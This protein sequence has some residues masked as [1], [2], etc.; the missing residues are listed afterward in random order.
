MS[1]RARWLA[2]AVCAVAGLAVFQFWGNS[3]R[4]YIDTR[5]LFY[6]WGWQWFDPASESEHGILILAAA[7]AL[8]VINFRELAGMAPTKAPRAQPAVAMLAGLAVH[9]LGYALQQTR[10]S[11]IGFLFF[12]WGA[13]ALGG[14]ARSARAA[15]F[16]LGFLVFAIPLNV[17]DT[18]GFYLRLGVIEVAYRL[19][20]AFGIGVLRNGTQ[21]LAPDGSY[22]YDVAAACSG[23]N[24]LMALAALSL[25]VGYLSFR[26]LRRRAL[27]ALLCV[28]FAFAGNVVRI[29]MII[30]VAAWKGQRA[31][32]VVHD[33]FGFLIFLIVLGLELGAVSLIRRWWPETPPVPATSGS[34]AVPPAWLAPGVIAAAV[35]LAATGMALAAH[36]LDGMQVDPRAGVR[37]AA[38]GVN[39]V[40]LP[41]LLDFDWAG[42]PVEVSAVERSVLPPD[43][44]FS[45]KRYESL[46]DRRQWVFLSIVLSGR[47]RTS[48]H[49]PEICLVGQGW[50]IMDRSSHEFA[51][52]GATTAKVPATLLRIEH[53]ATAKD[54]RKIRVPALFAY[55]FVGH[56]RT[57]ASNWERVWSSAMER[58]WHQRGE[59]WA[60]VVLQTPAGDGDAAA[61]ARMQDVLTRT[62]P[63]FA[64][65]GL[66]D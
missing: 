22:S 36:R 30:V 53:E 24:S 62:M 18:L 2:A 43:T 64:G 34:A 16:P 37:L 39:P 9:F 47:D 6:W 7:V 54:G 63:A 59:R 23:V 8:F 55:W 3:A 29:L 14:G 32:A 15:A 38:D 40:A 21:L 57:V 5:S 61:L 27:V 50:T 45:R 49:R 44:G 51:Q 48:I 66:K 19:A 60:Y 28:P 10:I 56:D 17:L 52:P 42:R 31:G 33:W 1:D 11:I 20:H 65:Q 58:L 12:A 35:G 46:T 13:V 41:D 25:L 4:G 26:T